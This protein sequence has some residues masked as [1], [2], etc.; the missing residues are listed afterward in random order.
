[1]SK[2]VNSLNIIFALEVI[3]VILAT[4][5]LVPREAILIWTGLAV[6]YIIFSS[7]EDSLWLVVAS[8]PLFAALPISDG[9]D[10]LANW[11]VLIVVLFLCLFFKKG[12]SLSLVREAGGR[13]RLR[14]NLKHYAVE[15]LAAGFLAVAAL[16]I[17][18]ASHK[19]LAVK[20]L[21]FIANIF[22]LFLV[23]RN[24]TRDKESIIKL[25]QAAMVGGVA[26]IG[27][28]IIQFLA[29]L[30]MPLYAFWQFWADKVIETFYGQN[31]S[32]L[33]SYANTWFAYY[34]KNPPTLRLFSVFPDSHSFAMFSILSLPIFLGLAFYYKT[35]QQ[36]K[37]NIFFWILSG[38]AL[39]GVVFSGSRGAWVGI[40]PASAALFYLLAKK[41]SPF[42]TKK[43][44][45]IFLIFGFLFLISSFYPP[46]FYKF[47]SW[48][49]GKINTSTFY[50]FE[51][52]RSIADAD[53][54]SN[55]GR[56]EIWQ[57]TLKSIA[58][59]PI[60]GVG[61]GNYI[62]VLDEDISAAKKGAS[63]HNLYLDFAAEIGIFGVLFLIGMFADVLYSCWLVFYYGSESY[64][65]FF[66]LL[67]GLSFIWILSYSFF[68]VVLLNDK[69]L[70]SFMVGAAILYNL[71]ELETQK[72]LNPKLDA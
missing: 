40:V 15:Y 70:L 49:T 17:L 19:I 64:F 48:Q 57:V 50:F 10:T 23:I 1:M 4:L 71:R 68:D 5:G 42:L 58:Q 24:L 51:R 21:L 3:V 8:I 44:L 43:S 61:L 20:K 47:Q 27:A 52:A 28:A 25:W 56:L 54:I 60:L 53:E 66:G 31:L 39:F 29:V 65:R 45:T 2:Y 69:V 11:R 12:I 6:F 32:Q 30:F 67:F 38:L 72:R 55:K 16:S 9:F 7:P 22:L 14:E 46:L 41:I 33:L 59:K 34:G 18:V 13:L 35:K 26:A 63:A 36:N 62:M 37:L